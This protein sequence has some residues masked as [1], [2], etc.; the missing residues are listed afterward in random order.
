MLGRRNDGQHHADD[1]P[2]T[3]QEHL[4]ELRGRIIKIVI[5]VGFGLVGGLLWA[6]H[7]EGYFLDLLQR[8]A[9]GTRV[10]ALSPQERFTVYCTIALYID[11][12]LAMPVILYQLLR[13]VAP[14]LTPGER[15]LTY[16][17]LPGAVACFAGGIA[18]SAFV[19]LPQMFRFLLNFGNPEIGNAMRASEVLNF[20][21]NLALWTGLA[22]ELPMVMFLLASLNVAPYDL[23]RRGRKYASVGLMLVAAIMTPSPDALSMII[24]WAPLYCLFEFGLILARFARPRAQVS[25]LALIAAAFAARQIARRARIGNATA[26]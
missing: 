11:I 5:A 6:N 26:A 14:G 3:L 22:F 8:V 12:A 4:A 25:T 20:C 17:L 1:E 21:A 24:V 7:V 18:F 10:I 23:L 16:L 19:T 9:P 2:M 15:R 13:F